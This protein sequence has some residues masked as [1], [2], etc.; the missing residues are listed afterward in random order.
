MVH[1]V[2]A[3]IVMAESRCLE[4]YRTS[5]GKPDIKYL[6]QGGVS[7]KESLKGL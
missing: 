3:F 1:G 2:K 5:Q 4:P 7:W 6:L